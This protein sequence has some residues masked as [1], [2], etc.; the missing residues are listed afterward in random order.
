MLLMEN[1]QPIIGRKALSYYNAALSP[2]KLLHE[3]AFNLR[4][5]LEKLIESIAYPI[6][7]SDADKEKY[8]IK[9]DG[10]IQTDKK[11]NPRKVNL[12]KRIN[13]LRPYF[14]SDYMA[15]LDSIRTVGNSFVH[16]GTD[17]DVSK[18]DVDRLFQIISKFPIKLFSTLFKKNGFYSEN[19]WTLTVLSVLPPY[20]RIRILNEY[21][22]YDKSPLVIEKLSMA[23][24]KNN[25][26]DEAF[27]L[28]ENTLQNNYLTGEEHKYLVE[29]LNLLKP[30]LLKFRIAKDIN[31]SKNALKELLQSI[32][33]EER[34]FCTK[35]VAIICNLDIFNDD[36]IIKNDN[37]YILLKA[38]IKVH[39]KNHRYGVNENN[40]I[41][42][43]KAAFKLDVNKLDRLSDKI[44]NIYKIVDIEEDY[45]MPFD[46]Q[47][48]NIVD[49]C[50]SPSF[51][52]DN[53]DRF[54]EIILNESSKAKEHYLT[55]GETGVMY[56]NKTLVF[57]LEIRK[58][59]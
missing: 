33:V 29:K 4:L 22:L 46:G 10:N 23:Y 37:K 2:N 52:S 28:L 53:I 58:N 20:Y 41:V 26:E 38:A 7:F 47:S 31:D 14:D 5:C 45:L 39:G 3:K 57:N 44:N 43:R 1:D 11:G 24:L 25:N 9:K 34:D 50:I 19:S 27:A 55:D 17:C 49:I 12:E 56:S 8:Y 15:E 54:K 35:L 42:S 32:K 13:I 21:F 18:E 40:I 59:S 51:V 48:G 6:L 16:E 30:N 36:K